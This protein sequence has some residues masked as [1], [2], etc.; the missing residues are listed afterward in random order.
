M[1]LVNPSAT[2]PPCHLPEGELPEGQEKPAWAVTQGRLMG[3]DHSQLA[4]KIPHRFSGVLHRDPVLWMDI[5]G[6]EYD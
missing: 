1:G 2:A 5:H 6:V 3:C 4:L